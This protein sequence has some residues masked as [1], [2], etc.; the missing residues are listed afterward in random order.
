LNDPKNTL[1]IGSSMGGLV[2]LY[3]GREFTAFGRIGVMSPALWISP[4]YIAQVTGGSKKPLR[5]YLD[6]GTGEPADD[7]ENCVEMY[8]AH[9][10]QSYA[11]N[12]EVLF[13]AG[14]GQQ[15]NEAAWK[16]RLP[17]ALDY[18]LPVREEPNQIAERD[19][20][21]RFAIGSIDVTGRKAAFNYT[22]FFGYV[23]TLERS[24]NLTKWDAVYTSPPEQ[25]P[26]ASH[27]ATDPLFPDGQW[28]WRLR[29]TAAP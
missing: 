12:S 26:W 25:M 20:P 8:D 1:T 10:A 13:V 21:A 22:G 18:L 6:M 28:F 15:H 7:F 4:N 5:V 3:L 14:C 9:L 27:V 24:T 17:A 2:S 19:L 16:Q 23:Y 11:A 29:S